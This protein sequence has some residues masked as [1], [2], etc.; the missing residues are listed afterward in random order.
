MHGMSRSLYIR[1]SPESR[2][3]TCFIIFLFHNFALVLFCLW[4]WRNALFRWCG[5]PFPVL[6]S[7]QI[8]VPANIFCV[9]PIFCVLL[10]FKLFVFGIIKLYD[11]FILHIYVNIIKVY[12]KLLFK[13]IYILLIFFINFVYILFKFFFA[14]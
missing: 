5:V 3:Y 6:R 9:L 12:A 1:R 11:I 7:R 13:Y 8:L 2:M 4:W 10:I 14:Y